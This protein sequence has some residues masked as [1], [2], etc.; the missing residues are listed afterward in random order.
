MLGVTYKTAWF[1]CHR[2]REAMTE[3]D[4]S[5]GPLGGERKTVEAEKTY[6]GKRDLPCLSPQRKGRPFIKK[7]GAAQKRTAVS[8][9]G[10]GGSVRSFHVQHATKDT[11]V[12]FKFAML[13]VPQ[14]SIPTRV[15]F[16]P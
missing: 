15:T 10:R 9:V 3:D 5:S 8:V 1:M 4:A 2:I 14:P 7:G 12:P 16:T 13:T 6:I 11:C